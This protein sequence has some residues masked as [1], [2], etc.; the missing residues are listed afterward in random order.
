MDL[1]GP[2]AEQLFLASST[3]HPSSLFIR[4]SKTKIFFCIIPFGPFCRRWGIGIYIR[5]GSL[6][7]LIWIHPW[8]GR[9]SPINAIKE[10]ALPKFLVV[11]MLPR[12]LLSDSPRFEFLV[13]DLACG[14]KDTFY[15][16]GPSLNG[17]LPITIPGCSL[18][19]K[20][21]SC[22]STWMMT[23]ERKMINQHSFLWWDDKCISTTSSE[24][25]ITYKHL[26]PEW[27]HPRY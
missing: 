16:L 14:L 18:T 27:R 2:T 4:F 12:Q 26:Y 22:Q 5:D 23:P 8:I 6:P 11:S 10:L 9:R 20:R 25:L 15:L 19:S 24:L 1:L 21:W 13:D 7:H 17:K 3:E